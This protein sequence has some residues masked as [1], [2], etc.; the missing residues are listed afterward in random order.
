MTPPI[1]IKCQVPGCKYKTPKGCP[2]WEL[3]YKDRDD[4]MLY[5]HP[6]PADNS[7][8]Q[9]V[10]HQVQNDPQPVGKSNKTVTNH[11]K[12]TL[13]MASSA[14]QVTT[15][16][17]SDEDKTQPSASCSPMTNILRNCGILSGEMSSSTPAITASNIELFDNPADEEQIAEVVVSEGHWSQLQYTASVVKPT[18]GGTKWRCSEGCMSSRNT[19]FWGSKQA[20]VKHIAKEHPDP[21]VSYFWCKLCPVERKKRNRIENEFDSCDQVLEHFRL[22]HKTPGT[23]PSMEEQYDSILACHSEDQTHHR[24][25]KRSKETWFIELDN[26][27]VVKFSVPIK[28][29][30]PQ[31]PCVINTK[32]Q[33]P[34]ASSEQLTL[35]ECNSQDILVTHMQKP[36]PRM[37]LPDP[38]ASIKSPPLFSQVCNF[39]P[40]CCMLLSYLCSGTCYMCFTKSPRTY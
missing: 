3:M 30:E 10:V 18:D 31:E 29:L 28:T 27:V 6:K 22:K 7:D 19:D 32:E 34:S 17:T 36:D 20:V 40:L 8:P 13:T 26:T 33:E 9:N 4:H 35:P 21:R 12:Q 2:T 37:M 15:Q 14:T 11:P 39:V 5:S 23:R 24:V 16:T 38:S 1:P 25:Q